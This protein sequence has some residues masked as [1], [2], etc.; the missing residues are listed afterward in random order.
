VQHPEQ[1]RRRDEEPEAGASGLERVNE[2]RH[3]EA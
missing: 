2:I 1:D 3:R